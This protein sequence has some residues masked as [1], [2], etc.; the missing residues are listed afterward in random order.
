MQVNFKKRDVG[1]TGVIG[2]LVNKKIS[3]LSKFDK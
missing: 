1:T 2:C 3:Y